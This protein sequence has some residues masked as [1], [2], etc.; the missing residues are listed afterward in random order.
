[1]TLFRLCLRNLLYHWRGNLAVLLGVVVGCAVLTG[2]L[3]VGDSLRGSLRD[4]TLQRLGPV[5]VALVAPRFFRQALASELQQD[6][7][8][9]RAEPALL[10]QATAA[11][12]Q[13]QARGVTVLGV[14]D[15][16][17]AL[18]GGAGPTDSV[19]INGPL[20]RAL[21]V[22]VGD[23][24]TLRLQKPSAIPREAALGKNKAEVQE[25]KL[26]VGRVLEGEEPGNL[27]NLRPELDAPRNAFVSLPALQK[28]L[29]QAGRVNAILGAGPRPD[30]AASLKARL[31]LEDWG[32]VLRG[33]KGRAGALFERL[34]KS[35]KADKLIR[36]EWR[37]DDGP[38]FA[39]IIARGMGLNLKRLPQELERSRIEAYYRTHHLYLS[40]ESKQLLLAPAVVEAAEAAAREMALRTAPTLV[41]LVRLH[42][43]E[44]VNAGIVAA[45]RP[46]GSAPL[47]PLVPAGTKDNQIVLAREGWGANVPKVGEKVVLTFRP[48]EHQGGAPDGRATFTVAAVRP[49]RGALADP[50]LTPELPGVTDVKGGPDAWELPFDDKNWDQKSVSRQYTTPY[51]N[52]YWTT[53]KA[54]VT[55]AAGKALWKSRFGSLTS[56]RLAP[57]DGGS[58][59]VAEARFREK[60]LARLSP[61]KGGFVFDEVKKTSLEASQGGTDFGGLF[62]GFSFFLIAAA[63]LLVGLLV[64][65]NLDRRASEI[66]LL[67]AEGFRRRTVRALLIG[68]GGLLALGGVAL[69]TLLA[70][71]YAGLLVRLLAALWPGGTLQSFLRPH[72]PPLSLVIGAVATLLVSTLT[73]AWVV[74][75]M[76]KVAPRALLAGQT[77]SEGELGLARRARWSGRIAVASLVLGV[78]VIAAGPFVPGHEAQAGTFFGGGALLLTASLAAVSAWMRR[79][80]HATVEGSGWWSV[81][82]LGVRNAARHPARSLLTAGLLASAAFLLV[83]VEVFRR[84]ATAGGGAQSPDGGFALL[85]ESDLPVVRD[86]QSPEGHNELIARLPREQAVEARALLEDEGTK[87]VAFRVRGGDDASCLNLYQPRRPRVLGVPKA[88]IEHG[89]FAFAG[90]TAR[91]PEEKAHPWTILQR[92]EG[93]VPV[94]GEANTVTWMLKSGLGKT[95]KTPDA[96]GAETDLVI[97]GLLQDSVFQSSLLMSEEQ[98]LRLYPDTEGQQFFLI[99]APR[100]KEAELKRILER[101]LADRGFEVSYVKDRLESYLA[102]ENTYLSTFQALGGLGLVLGSLGLAV[103]LLRGVW[104]RRG[105]LALLRAL[106]FRRSMLGWMVLAENAFLLVLGL[107]AGTASALLSV[108]PQLLA[109]S[110]SV[111]WLGL[112]GLLAV[113]LV[114]GLLAGLFAVVT[115]LRAPLVPALRRE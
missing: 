58:L 95:I 68:E 23:S 29:G 87:I 69:G 106:G 10:L 35:P 2:A 33:P 89:G 11:G 27:F 6:G 65:L 3:L 92:G 103:V 100:G 91:T 12:E 47:G 7:A 60:L 107:A 79:D 49:I 37:G 80:K 86:L 108:A 39:G 14:R 16:L 5:D 41:Y 28:E 20:A 94:F 109:G 26:P 63:L 61:E 52:E 73:I 97:D 24:I 42:H 21:D 51:W 54:Y 101:G 88:L 82:R 59:D 19:W 48:A 34:A 4:R 43:G 114:V 66:G 8:L 17:L 115:T 77:T 46:G 71:A 93:P 113:V 15:G 98:F 74:R 83:A 31:T 36:E 112:L 110:G 18:G 40:L 111:P 38:L 99:Q 50:G 9:G 90:T 22:K 62:L 72:S 44:S 78:A 30:L 45:V 55:L 64:R 102:V 25:W 81:A 53:P 67:F 32:L 96:N 105:E 76:S 13:A 75:G 1:M 56:I 57:A 85:A 70:I 84:H 104:E